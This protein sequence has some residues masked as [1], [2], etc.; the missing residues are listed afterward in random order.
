[1]V[2]NCSNPLD[3]VNTMYTEY[4]YPLWYGP[5]ASDIEVDS[6][7][8]AGVDMSKYTW[9]D[10]DKIVVHAMADGEWG[11]TQF[12]VSPDTDTDRD[13]D[14]HFPLPQSFLFYE[15]DKSSWRR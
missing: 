7:Q 5:W 14:R 12:K 9:K 4:N 6:T 11:G 2:Q 15:T 3:C 13:R 8:D 1:M 10:A